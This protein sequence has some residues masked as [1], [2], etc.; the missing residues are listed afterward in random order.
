VNLNIFAINFNNS[1]AVAAWFNPLI[2][3]LSFASKRNFNFPFVWRLRNIFEVDCIID[4]G[5]YYW[6][7]N[8]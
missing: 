3:E 7:I 8:S 1:V 2:H 5:E 6:A 4:D